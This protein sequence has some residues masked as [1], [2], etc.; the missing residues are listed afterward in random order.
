MSLYFSRGIYTKGKLFKTE[1]KGNDKKGY[2]LLFPKVK[3][4]RLAMYEAALENLAHL[5]LEGIADK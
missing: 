1:A 2:F 5:I 3:T 4:N